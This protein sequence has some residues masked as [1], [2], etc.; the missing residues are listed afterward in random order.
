M[1]K[2][3]N[4][5]SRTNINVVITF[6]VVITNKFHP[7]F[8]C[9][10]VTSEHVFVCKNSWCIHGGIRERSL[11]YLHGMYTYLYTYMYIYINYKHIYIYIYISAVFLLLTLSIYWFLVYCLTIWAVPFHRLIFIKHFAR[12]VFTFPVIPLMTCVAISHV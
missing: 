7:F 6:S 2:I 9:S 5:G 12:Y 3:K 11:L 1:F 10:V 8:L 4:K